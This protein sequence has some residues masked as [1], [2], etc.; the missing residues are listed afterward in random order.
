MRYVR[1]TYYDGHP[2]ALDEGGEEQERGNDLPPCGAT[3]DTPCDDHDEGDERAEFDGDVKGD[4]EADSA[5]HVAEGFIGA[6]LFFAG[7]SDVFGLVRDVGV[8]AVEAVGEFATV[9]VLGVAVRDVDSRVWGRRMGGKTHCIEADPAR[10][11]DARDGHC[12]ACDRPSVML[13]V[14]GGKKV[15]HSLAR[16]SHRPTLYTILLVMMKSI[17]LLPK[18][19]RTT[20]K[21]K[22][23]R[24]KSATQ[25]I[26]RQSEVV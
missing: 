2:D 3:L 18:Q 17:F 7:E 22:G 12:R 25:Q 24:E 19:R 21:K 20:Q 13:T 4:E 8:A 11:V 26:R 23:S 5:P 14:E 15:L 10:H 6:A 9:V 1:W 16:V